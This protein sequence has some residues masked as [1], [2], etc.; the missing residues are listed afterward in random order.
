M[1]VRSWLEWIL[2]FLPNRDGATNIAHWDDGS[3]APAE[4]LAD[5]RRPIILLSHHD[6]LLRDA[7][8]ARGR[9][10]ILAQPASVARLA[11]DKRAMADVAGRVDG[12]LPI[13]HLTLAEALDHLA[14]PGASWIVAK[15]VG[16]TEGREL[17]VVGSP[18]ELRRL[19]PTIGRDDFVLQ[20]ALEGHEYSVN[21]I[22]D[23]RFCHVYAPV[24]KGSNL[25]FGVHPAK[26]PRTFPARTTR[27][28]SARL[29]AAAAGYA[30]AVGA[31][32]LVEVE[33]LESDGDLYL[34]EFNPRLSAT[35]RMSILGSAENLLS[36]LH[37]VLAGG[38][39]ESRFVPPT[40]HAF[41]IPLPPGITR[42]ALT[43]LRGLG[44]V[45][46]SSRITV[47]A[48]NMGLLDDLRYRASRVLAED[49]HARAAALL[50]TG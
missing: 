17:R 37:R 43:A 27:S 4:L 30:L 41:E 36:S 23:D 12:L 26:R 14:S 8:L 31:R 7:E 2:P 13:P 34:V 50:V 16:S 1:S 38:L 6:T 10:N 24:S 48:P 49:G 33:L 18:D 19:S 35:L 29:M 45:H 15:P 20:P 42:R 47:A 11:H 44:D 39:S 32:G 5:D 46:L 9:A 28:T 22:V 21:L 40:G 25:P 3:P